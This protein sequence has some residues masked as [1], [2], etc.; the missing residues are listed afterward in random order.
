LY[1]EHKEELPYR[2][3]GEKKTHRLSARFITQSNE[4]VSKNG[5]YGVLQRLSANIG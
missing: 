3:C 1:F 2:V 4:I 5:K